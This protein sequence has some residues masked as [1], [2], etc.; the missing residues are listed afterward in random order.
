MP[1]K[2][3]ST[4]LEKPVVEKEVTTPTEIEPSTII[5]EDSVEVS[6][7]AEVETQLPQDD[8]IK[9]KFEIEVDTFNSKLS[10]ALLAVPLKPIHPSLSN[11]LLTALDGQ[12]TLTGF[13][14]N[15]GVTIC[16]DAQIKIPGTIALPAKL[17][18]S[19]VSRMPTGKVTLEARAI[20][21]GFVVTLTCA[22][23]GQYQIRGTVKEDFPAL[24]ELD[25]KRQS[26]RVKPLLLAAGLRTVLF[27]AASDETKPILS[28]VYLQ[29]DA[30]GIELAATDSYRLAIASIPN[31]YVD[32]ENIPS[33]SVTIPAARVQQIEKILSANSAETVTVEFDSSK[34]SLSIGNTQLTIR[35][36][37]GEYPSYRQLIPNEV[38]TTV[39]IFRRQFI[40]IL[41]RLAVLTDNNHVVVA[42]IN[43]SE[44]SLFLT[45]ETADLG[46]G[47][48][49][50]SAKVEGESIEIGLNIK[51]VLEALKKLDTAWVEL[52]INSPTTPV[53]V[54]PVE[55]LIPT[56]QLFMPILIKS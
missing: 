24:P 31:P 8:D 45:V 47:V 50:I 34:G 56:T 37:E 17:L 13:D 38:S 16:C 26:F 11:V 54:S 18:Q 42:N 28:G 53:I 20:S 48:E 2:N 41:E 35:L 3:Q 23:S 46:R 25:S 27:A 40:D 43:Q 15:L 39:R 14:F 21:R 5:T 36:L 4:V 49:T 1:R 30:D 44:Q 22:S 10:T 9:L 51:Y 19:I 7:M 33:V 32:D 55:S 6:A 29:F 52:Q 12:I